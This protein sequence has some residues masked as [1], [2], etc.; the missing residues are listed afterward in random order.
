[1]T[2]SEI[3]QRLAKIQREIAELNE[4][5]ALIENPPW[6]IPVPLPQPPMQPP[7]IPGG[8]YAYMCSF[9]EESHQNSQTFTGITV[10]ST[11]P[12]GDEP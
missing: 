7:R 12:K 3:R 8:V 10:T 1:M 5:L 4:S 9:P 11:P 2:Y 6:P